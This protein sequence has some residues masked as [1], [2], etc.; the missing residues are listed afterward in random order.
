MHGDG[1]CSRWS[2]GGEGIEMCGI[3]GYAGDDALPVLLDGLR[4]LEYRGYD[5]AGVGLEDGSLRVYR[6]SGEVSEIERKVDDVDS[7]PV[8]VGH[9]RWSTHGAPV[10]KNAHPQVDCTGDVAVVHNGIVEN[11]EE[12]RSELEG[13]GHSFTS[14]T[15]TEVVAHLVE[16]RVGD[17]LREALE[18]AT[19][20]LEGS[21]AVAVSAADSG[22]VVAARQDSPLLVAYGGGCN[23][24]ASDAPAVVN[25]TKEVTYLEDGDVAVLEADSV[26]FYRDGSEFTPDVDVIDWDAEEAEKGGYPHYMLKEIHEQPRALRRAISGR[27]DA[28]EGEVDVEVDLP[29]DVEDIDVVACGTSYHAGLYAETLLEEYAGLRVSVDYASEYTSSADVVVAVTQSGETADTLSAVRR[30]KADGAYVVAVTNTVGSTVT[31][32]ADDTVYIRAGPEIGVAA[33]KTFGSQVVTLAALAVA[34]GRERD[35][36]ST[37]AAS[38]L[39]EDLQGSPAQFNRCSTGTAR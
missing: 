1:S 2:E 8:G 26:S 10:E 14:D 32:E 34:W 30:A 18:H 25:R 24:L 27:F 33:T 12:L 6:S 36:L 28:V 7:A 17:G 5:S 23:Y 21:Y 29:N 35:E 20:R 22:R 11:H 4:R 19:S 16:E 38:E 31:R 15:D 3:I 37:V 39:I 13:R 9:T